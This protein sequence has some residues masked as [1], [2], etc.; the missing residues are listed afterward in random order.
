MMEETQF[1]SY[2]AGH[3]SASY[4]SSSQSNYTV[5]PIPYRTCAGLSAVP[6]YDSNL[7]FNTIYDPNQPIID[8]HPDEMVGSNTEAP[9]ELAYVA[10]LTPHHIL[11]QVQQGRFKPSFSAPSTPESPSFKYLPPGAFHTK[12][13]MRRSSN[14]PISYSSVP[15]LKM[16]YE[17]SM[18]M[19]V[20]QP[21]YIAVDG[22]GEYLQDVSSHYEQPL[23]QTVNYENTEAFLQPH[24]QGFAKPDAFSPAPTAISHE[25]SPSPSLPITPPPSGTFPQQSFYIHQQQMMSQYVS[26]AMHHTGPVPLSSSSNLYIR[27]T[28]SFNPTIVLLVNRHSQ[29]DDGVFDLFVTANT[30]WDYHKS[31]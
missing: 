29:L 17:D 19:M 1:S 3:L 4:E 31:N 30:H 23:L 25:Y 22:N 21:S 11:T 9:P 26:V 28:H 15:T 13:L 14:I 24:S 27:R 18:Q 5:A 7:T 6:I 10:Q 8:I 16:D 2:S 20:D 12:P